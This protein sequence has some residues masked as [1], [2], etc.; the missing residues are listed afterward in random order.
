[1][2]LS[3]S[4]KAYEFPVRCD[5]DLPVNHSGVVGANQIEHEC[6]SLGQNGAPNYIWKQSV[7]VSSYTNLDAVFQVV[8]QSVEEV[9]DRGEWRLPTYKEL[10]SLVTYDAN[11]VPLSTWAL[12]QAWNSPHA[13]NPSYILSASY[14]AENDGLSGSNSTSG[15]VATNLSSGSSSRITLPIASTSLYAPLVQ[16]VEDVFGEDV[17]FNSF[18]PNDGKCFDLSLNALD[19]PD[20]HLKKWNCKY[21]ST[22]WNDKEESAQM[23]SYNVYNQ[24]FRS[25]YVYY[26]S[27]VSYYKCVTANGGFVVNAELTIEDCRTSTAK[28]EFVANKWIE[29]NSGNDYAIGLVSGK[30][31]LV[32]SAS[33]LTWQLAKWDKL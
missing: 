23:W 14:L 29:K 30:L 7:D 5:R 28:W 20:G 13:S 24:Q 33:A 21:K 8:F 32:Q 19:S 6:Y 15:L 2:L 4:S 1:M 18:P 25:K 31:A 16:K 3:V 27:G 11:S 26:D 12:L 17:R 10:S 22:S 9:A